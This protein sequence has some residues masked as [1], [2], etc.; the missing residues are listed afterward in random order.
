MHQL[1]QQFLGLVGVQKSGTTW[2]HGMLVTHPQIHMSPIKEP[3]YFCDLR[4]DGLASTAITDATLWEYLRQH[5]GGHSG[6]IREEANYQK[7]LI[8]PA[9]KSVV[10]EA[11]VSY[12]CCR[13]APRRLAGWCPAAKI[14]VIVRDPI[15][16][17]WSHASMDQTLGKFSQ[18][19][20]VVLGNELRELETSNLLATRYFR[21]SFYAE[22]LKRY[23]A[24]FSRERVLVLPFA[25]I[26]ADPKRL[27]ESVGRFLNVRTDLF[28]DATAANKNVSRPPR[29]PA[30][31]ACIEKI[32]IKHFIRKNSPANLLALGKNTFYKKSIA[33]IGPDAEFRAAAWPYFQ[34]DIDATCEL[35]GQDVRAWYSSEHAV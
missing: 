12:F 10:G 34:A 4:D 35:V 7:L 29:W 19:V 3:N 16:R 27:L 9:D 8:A 17:A 23:I 32:G 15:A 13:N 33:G 22:A 18:P 26:K 30:L 31:N 20:S 28:R 14:I 6:W 25:D 1:K 5:D 2:L 21:E 11:S 24:L